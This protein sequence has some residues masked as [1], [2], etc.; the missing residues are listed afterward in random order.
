MIL[1][2][3]PMALSNY[4]IQGIIFPPIFYKFISPNQ[5]EVIICCP[6]GHSCIRKKSRQ[7][8]I[9]G[10]SRDFC[11]MLHFLFK[12]KKLELFPTL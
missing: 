12:V 5:E 3:T 8:R 2:L 6:W 4:Q 9:S 10:K 11:Q 1:K 7:S